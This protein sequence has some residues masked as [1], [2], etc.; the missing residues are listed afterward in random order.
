MSL[1]NIK[2]LID[3]MVEQENFISTKLL[4]RFFHYFALDFD[5]RRGK[6]AIASHTFLKTKFKKTV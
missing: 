5:N 2:D 6:A 1:E 3:W 4:L